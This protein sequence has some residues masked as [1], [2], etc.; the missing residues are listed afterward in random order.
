MAKV[1]ISYS[2]RDYISE[3]GAI[4]EGCPIARILTA[5]SEAGIAYWIDREGLEAGVTYAEKIAKNIKDCEV[6]LFVST[7]NSNASEWTLR[8]I[9]SAISFGKKIIPVRIDHSEYAEPVALYLSSV[10]YIDWLELGPSES[11]RR[12]VAKIMDPD[13]EFTTVSEYGSI[14]R[15]TT[16]IMC[17]GLVFLCGVYALLTYHFLWAN[18]LRSSEI[19]GGLVGFVC[20]FSV[21]MS[22]YYILR[23]MRKRRCSF[24]VPAA[25]VA[26]VFLSGMMLR[27]QELVV[28]SALLVIGW[29]FLFLASFIKSRQR[30]SLWSQLSKEQVLMKWTDSENLILVYLLIK[31][32]VLVFA[33][34]FHATIATPVLSP[35]MF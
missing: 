5:L 14:P 22:I 34:Y 25:I 29:F 4:I 31:C 30:R 15:L 9:S 2:K 13:A 28:I 19:L 26:I 35:F 18:Q 27:D 33:H 1:F 11:I 23:L 20:E 6:F 16:A 7:K 21:L 32:F 3:D 17:T 12:I 24:I 10:Q 8:E